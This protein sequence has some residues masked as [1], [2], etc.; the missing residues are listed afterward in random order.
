MVASIAPF[1]ESHVAPEPPPASA[2]EGRMPARRPA[3]LE[4][5]DRRRLNRRAANA[6]RQVRLGAGRYVVPSTT[7]EADGPVD[8]HAFTN[9]L[10]DGSVDS[11][12]AAVGPVVCSGPW[13]DAV[14]DVMRQRRPNG[15]P[16]V[17]YAVRPGGKLATT[18][19]KLVEML[20]AAGVYP[21][22]ASAPANRMRPCCCHVCARETGSRLRSRQYPPNHV[23]SRGLSYDCHQEQR[24]AEDW[25][26]AELDPDAADLIEMDRARNADVRHEDGGRLRNMQPMKVAV[27][28]AWRRHPIRRLGLSSRTA[29][30]A[31]MGF[32]WRDV[33]GDVKAVIRERRLSKVGDLADYVEVYGRR[34]SDVPGLTTGATEDVLVRLAAYPR[35]GNLVDV[36]YVRPETRVGRANTLLNQPE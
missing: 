17:P 15:R 34:L 29:R 25:I 32:R 6:A 14:D 23:G 28:D 33:T 3:A 27:P 1:G 31:L 35:E 20:D 8:P 22:A 24:A 11:L 16:V 12:W 5:V 10:W 19:V 9:G 21:P 18:P 13:A 36:A 4:A 30:D 26:A 2:F 7:D